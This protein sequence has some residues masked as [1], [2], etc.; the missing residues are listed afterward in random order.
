MGAL[1]VEKMAEAVLGY[2]FRI[3][4]PAQSCSKMGAPLPKKFYKQYFLKTFE[5]VSDLFTLFNVSTHVEN[6][7]LPPSESSQKC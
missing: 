1:H 4:F 3:A 2:V 5:W 7:I 6:I